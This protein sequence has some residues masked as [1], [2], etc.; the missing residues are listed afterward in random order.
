MEVIK[1]GLNIGYLTS[2]KEDSELYTLAFAVDSIKNIFQRTKN[3]V[4]ILY[5]NNRL[6]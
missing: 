6:F 5:G 1:I 2:D 3:L 4:S